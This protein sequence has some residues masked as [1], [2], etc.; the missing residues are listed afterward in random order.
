[1]YRLWYIVGIMFAVIIVGAGKIHY[2]PY[3]KEVESMNKMAAAQL[4][5]EYQQNKLT[6]EQLEN[7]LNI[8]ALEEKETQ[9]Y[10]DTLYV[11]FNSLNNKAGLLNGTEKDWVYYSYKND[12]DYKRAVSISLWETANGT[13]K[14][15][16]NQKNVA[17]INLTSKERQI[18]NVSGYTANLKTYQNLE[19]S[20]MATCRKLKDYKAWYG[21]ETLTQ[22]KQKYCPD[23]DPRSANN[24]GSYGDNTMWLSQTIK[25]YKAIEVI[26]DRLRR[27]RG[28]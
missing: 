8:L 16:K 18:M 6:K 22:I 4:Q 15:I 28:L 9:L 13:S 25:H 2:Q 5:L 11:Y 7:Q 17:G 3:A 23:S 12:I 26:E 20:I 10:F 19:E 24:G 21:A 1:M 27:E 14:A